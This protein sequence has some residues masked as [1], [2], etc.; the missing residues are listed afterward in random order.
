MATIPPQARVNRHFEASPERVYDAWLTPAMLGKWMFGPAV[1]DEEVV[2][3]TLDARAGGTYSFVVRRQGT[4]L[5]HTG[6]YLELIRPRWLA[7]TWGTDASPERSR[8]AIDIVPLAP[9]VELTLTH[10]LP[11]DWADFASRAAAAWAHML[12]ALARTL[13]EPLAVEQDR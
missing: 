1:R 12:D 6:E 5:D 8:V 4:L 11:P 7:F 2:R 9:G 13:D 3:I 10:E